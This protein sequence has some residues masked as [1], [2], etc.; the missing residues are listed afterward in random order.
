MEKLSSCYISVQVKTY[1][2]KK[3]VQHPDIKI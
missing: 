2:T 3:Q 1:C